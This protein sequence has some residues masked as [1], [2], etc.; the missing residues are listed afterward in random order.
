M[1][2]KVQDRTTEPKSGEGIKRSTTLHHKNEKKEKP[3]GKEP[4]T[5]LRT[6]EEMRKREEELAQ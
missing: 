4:K 2:I 1:A 5:R 6:K 3:R